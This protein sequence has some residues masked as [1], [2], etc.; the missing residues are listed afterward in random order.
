MG[1]YLKQIKHNKIEA[2][3][4]GCAE[5][6]SAVIHDIVAAAFE[7]RID[8]LF[9][10]KNVELWGRYDEGKMFVEVHGSKQ[11]DSI[12]LRDVIVRK[13]LENEGKIF[14]LEPSLMPEKE[15]CIN[16]VFRY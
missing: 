11:G 10:Q 6:K 7:G 2:Y 5:T 8:T 4:E 1:D 16:A 13:V 12:S 9:I 14:L 15:S 3:S